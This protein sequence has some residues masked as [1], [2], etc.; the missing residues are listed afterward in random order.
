MAEVFQVLRAFGEVAK[1]ASGAQI[2][3]I[4]GATSNTGDHMINMHGLRGFDSVA[5]VFATVAPV[6]PEP[7]LE[8]VCKV[9]PVT[10]QDL[11]VFVDFLCFHK[12]K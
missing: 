3:E 12:A 2:F 4:V 5:A 7:R 8:C 9:D 11:S 6:V 1:P 10:G